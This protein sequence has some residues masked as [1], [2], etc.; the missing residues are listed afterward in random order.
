M[1]YI[2]PTIIILMCAGVIGVLFYITTTEIDSTGK[3][4]ADLFD[5]AK[6]TWD[7]VMEVL[8]FEPN[9]TTQLT[10]RW[11]PPEK[12]YNHI[13]IWISTASG[14]LLK[15]ESGEHDRVSLDPDGL[16][17]GTEYVFAIQACID[18]DC[19]RWYIGQDEYRGTTERLTEEGDIT[20]TIDAE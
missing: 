2:L 1:K 16:E 13:V 10:I 19:K 11:Q 8:P 20:E 7:P 17:P 3:I 14:E 5:Q 6:R 12:D 4:H 18:P 15:S 9:P